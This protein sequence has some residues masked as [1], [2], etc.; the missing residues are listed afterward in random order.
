MNNK[1]MVGG[2]FCDIQKAFDCVSHKILL[3]KLI[4]YG[5][6]GKFKTLIESYLMDRYQ[7]VVIGNR[8]DCRSSS[9][10]ELIKCGVPQ[11]SILGPLFFLLFIN[12]LPASINKNN[13]MVLFA[14]DMSIIV[15]DTNRLDFGTNLNQTLNDIV[16]WFNANL[17]TLNFN[18]SQYVEFRSR[19][20]HNIT[21]QNCRGSY[22]ITQGDRN[23]IS[24][25]N[26]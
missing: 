23:K 26:H 8:S 3:D 19:N 18:K 6:E 12:D 10:W 22:K 4:F 20:Y 13:K 7:R 14:D 5:I 24:R 15:T 9:E 1:L 17:L 2:I 21:P 16:S 11:G 25:V